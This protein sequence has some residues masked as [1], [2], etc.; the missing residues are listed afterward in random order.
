MADGGL[1]RDGAARQDCA[2]CQQ[3]SNGKHGATAVRARAFSKFCEF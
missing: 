3:G 1:A 2:G